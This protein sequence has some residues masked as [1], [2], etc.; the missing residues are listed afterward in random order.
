LVNVKFVTASSVLL[1]LL[2][3]VYPFV[4]VRA[5]SGAGSFTILLSGYAVN[6]ELQN[7]VIS[8]DG[9]IS[10][11][12]VLDGTASTSLGPIP[13]TANGVWIGVR[14]GTT[15]SGAIE[16]VAG[17]ANPCFLFWCDIATFVGQG[18]WSGALTANSTLGSGGF[19]GTITFTSSDFPQVP[20]GQSQPIS[21]T[22]N[23][24]LT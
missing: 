24:N 2:V 18:E 6:G 13:I 8:S 4:A 19:E 17:S 1:L 15:L 23:A 21:G 9:S 3:L 20:V 14:N 7:V 10:M 5:D 22:W 16:D 12:M 11:N